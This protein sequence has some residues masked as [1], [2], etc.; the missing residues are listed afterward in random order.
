MRRRATL[1]GVCLALILLAPTEG[2]A[3]SRSRGPCA[4]RQAT[5]DCLKTNFVR[6]HASDSRRFS[7][8]LQGAERRA[9]RCAAAPL[10]AAYLEVAPYTAGSTEVAEAVAEAIERWAVARPRCFLDALARANEAAQTWVIHD[11]R[12]PVTLDPADIRLKF[13][14]YRENTRYADI[15]GALFAPPATSLAILKDGAPAPRSR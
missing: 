8:I 13:L 12:A 4:G 6:L 5:L 11:L 2:D 14:R 1:V 7:Y 9:T 10:G 15:M 3:A